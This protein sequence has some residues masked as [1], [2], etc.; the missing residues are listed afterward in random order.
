MTPEE[1]RRNFSSPNSDQLSP[2][3]SASRLMQEMDIPP[4]KAISTV[5]LFSNLRSGC[6][7]TYTRQSAHLVF[8]GMPNRN[9]CFSHVRITFRATRCSFCDEHHLKSE[10]WELRL[11]RTQVIEW[12]VEQNCV[13]WLQYSC[14]YCLSL[15][16]YSP[17]LNIYSV[18]FPDSLIFA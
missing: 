2:S 15:K 13:Q 10:V 9:G 1:Q 8:G 12:K 6:T 11:D 16:L 18:T 14:W 17:K 5:S 3:T 4:L 7:F